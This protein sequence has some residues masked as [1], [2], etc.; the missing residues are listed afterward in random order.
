MKKHSSYRNSKTV[1]MGPEKNDPTKQDDDNDKTE[2]KP[3][4]RDP[5]KI[6]PTRIDD[7]TKIDPTR[8]DDPDKNPNKIE[9]PRH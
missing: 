5:K 7:P 8:I 9:P 6:D 1:V 2:P 4:I 3:G